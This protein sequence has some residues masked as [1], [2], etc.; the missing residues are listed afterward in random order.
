METWSMSV[1]Q[2]LAV[3]DLWVGLTCLYLAM[4]AAA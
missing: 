1:D 2:F 3:L 4:R